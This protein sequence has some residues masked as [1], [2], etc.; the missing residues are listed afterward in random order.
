VTHSMWAA[1]TYA[2]RLVVLLDGRVLLDGPPREVLADAPVL[3]QARLV[4]PEVVQLS[5]ALGFLA[6]TP[7]E[8]RNRLGGPA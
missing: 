2:R 5:R 3:A 8:F 1:A 7:A 4:A 6:L